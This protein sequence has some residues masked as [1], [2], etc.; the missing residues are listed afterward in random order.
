MPFPFTLPTTSNLSYPTFTTSSTHPSLPLAASTQRTVLRNVLKRHR[1]LSIQAQPADLNTV[2]SAIREYL[3]Y[4][5]TLNTG[6]KQRCVYDE[7]VDVTLRTEILAQWQSTLAASIPGKSSSRAKAKGIDFEVCFAFTTLALVYYGQ[8]RAQ[9]RSLYG[10]VSPTAEQRLGIITTAIKLF[11]DANSIH[12]YLSSHCLETDA[13]LGVVEALSQ[14]Q[15][16]LASLTMAEATLLAVLKDDPYP[17][18][19]AQDRNKDDREWMIKPPDIPKV[20]AHLFARLCL[21]AGDHAGK[22]QAML[23]A[24]GRVDEDLLRYVFDLKRTSRARACRFFGIDAELGGETGKGIAWLIGGRKEL[25]FGGKRDETAKLKGIAK[26]KKDW[27]ERRED[28]RVEKGGE[29]GADA[30]R[31]EELRVIEMLEQKWNKMND[32]VRSHPI[33]TMSKSSVL[34]LPQINTQLVPPSDPL[35]ASL[36]SGR[37]IHSIKSF[38]PPQLDGQALIRVRAPPDASAYSNDGLEDDSSDEEG[39]ERTERPPG[40]FPDSTTGS[41]HSGSYY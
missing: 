27:T 5:T 38:T 8:A 25:G 14:T 24:S 32:T 35:L 21:A 3:P 40:A 23:S 1:K 9:L 2:L 34:S 39:D 4:L 37:D 31:L 19:V 7:E 16:G 6:L 30:G 15:G 29:W 12:V 17:V 18:V 36:P 13:S 28:R 22:A 10:S 26:L 11:L 20:R 41:S 33:S